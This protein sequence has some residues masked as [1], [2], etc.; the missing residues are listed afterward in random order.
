[1][2]VPKLPSVVERLQLFKR[3]KI[4]NTELCHISDSSFSRVLVQLLVELLHLFPAYDSVVVEDRGRL[5]LRDREVVPI[6]F[7]VLF[8]LLDFTIFGV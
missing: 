5:D 6:D 2:F 7:G 8:V 1:M 3:Q 4:P